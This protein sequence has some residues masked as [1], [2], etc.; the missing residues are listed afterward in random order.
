MVI[1]QGVEIFLNEVTLGEI[2]DIPINRI[3][4]VWN[5]QPSLEFV[6]STSKI[7]R[8]FKVGV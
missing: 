3:R 7:G 1:V 4:S 8:N 6:Y 2:L 5:Q